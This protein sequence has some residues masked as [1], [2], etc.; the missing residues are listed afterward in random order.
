MDA[1]LVEKFRNFCGPNLDGSQGTKPKV[2]PVVEL[3]FNTPP[4]HSEGALRAR[5]S[6]Q[7]P[8]AAQNQASRSSRKRPAVARRPSMTRAEDVQ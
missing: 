4:H 1:V 3:G 2:A 5:T 7:M 6:S 8:P